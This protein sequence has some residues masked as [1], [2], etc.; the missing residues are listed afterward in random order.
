MRFLSK[1]A[2]RLAEDIRAIRIQ[3][4]HRVAKYGIIAF[5]YEMNVYARRSR[6]PDELLTRARSVA[7][8]LK[9][10]RPTEPMLINYLDDILY[11]IN[12]LAE[13]KRLSSSVLRGYLARKLKTILKQMDG[14]R[15]RL[16]RAGSR[17]IKPGDRILVHCHST[18]VMLTLKT[19]WNSG[20]RFEV[21]ATETRPLYQGHRTV[22]DLLSYGIPTTLIVDSGVGTVIDEIDKVFVGGDAVGL[23]GQLANKIGTKT[24]AELAY[25]RGIPFYSCVEL[26]K[27]DR[28]PDIPI[29]YRNPREVLAHIPKGLKVLN[30]AFD[31]T[32]SKHI[33]G[34]VTEQGVLKPREY[35]RTAEKV[36]KMFDKRMLP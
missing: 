36:I 11:D 27:L 16:A 14:A 31:I 22:R 26:Y 24:I 32:P 33:S 30:P 17:L 6:G 2:K 23:N 25:R 19:A 29:E 20:K 5:V 28:R 10:L 35:V 3:G 9:G 8:M 7:D 12:N 13:Q 15:A 1:R 4:A 34:F 21:V 18:S